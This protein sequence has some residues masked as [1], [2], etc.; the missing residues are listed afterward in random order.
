MKP[1]IIKA[2]TEIILDEINLKEEEEIIVYPYK[3]N[4]HGDEIVNNL[5]IIANINGK[6]AIFADNPGDIII[7]KWKGNRDYRKKV[8]EIEL[9]SMDKA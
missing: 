2:E 6:I 4:Q 1:A 9:S 8:A 5:L 7:E 3:E